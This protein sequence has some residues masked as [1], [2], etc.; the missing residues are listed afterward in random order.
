MY[1][2]MGFYTFKR[3]LI[4]NITFQSSLFLPFMLFCLSASVA[5]ITFILS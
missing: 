2:D 5:C 3:N 4:E 1:T